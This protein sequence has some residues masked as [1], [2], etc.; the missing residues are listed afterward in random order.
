[1]R[2]ALISYL[3]G[4]TRLF[5]ALFIALVGYIVD[6]NGLRGQYPAATA[7]GIC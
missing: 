4:L 5:F 7:G 6:R 2:A 1:M 3:V